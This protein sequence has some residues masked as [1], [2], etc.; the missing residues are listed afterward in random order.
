MRF[1]TV[2][3]VACA[4]GNQ[5]AV[6][7][8]QTDSHPIG[9]APSANSL[10]A[11]VPS[12]SGEA[13]VSTLV[14]SCPKEMVRIQHSYCIDRY[15]GSL[16]HQTT[17]TP[18]SPY[19]PP[20]PAKA[21]VVH[22]LWQ[23]SK[24]SGNA[25]EQA[26]QLPPLGQWQTLG[27]FA[28]SAE[29][30]PGIVPQGYASGEDA[31]RACAAAGKRLCTLEEWRVACR[32]E[33]NRDF[34][35]GDV[36]QAGKCNIFGPAHPGILLYDDPSINHTDPR[37]NLLK[38]KGKPLLFRTGSLET[39]RSDWEGDAVFD[40]VGNL[41]EWIDDP[42]GS[43]VGGFYARSKKDGCASIVSSH[44]FDYADYSTGLRCCKSVDRLL[45]QP[46]SQ[47]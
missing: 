4:C 16:V 44:S 25:L 5:D 34:P 42:E 1:A 33:A 30:R 20:T 8:T 47:P 41:D 32:G 14:P 31:K 27:D 24:G 18:L 39:C 19:Y 12:A 38:H 35:Y 17:R 21:K 46:K 29:S 40:M 6:G 2:C 28:A 9:T 3:L 45:E 11:P 23:R 36:Y 7:N 22:G 26:T 10:S 13:L 43:F 37:L 15:E